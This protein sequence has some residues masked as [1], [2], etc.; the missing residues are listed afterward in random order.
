MKMVNRILKRFGLKRLSL[1]LDQRFILMGILS[2]TAK[3]LFRKALALEL[4]KKLDFTTREIKKAGIEISNQEG[5][6]LIQLAVK[7]HEITRTF[8]ITEAQRKGILEALKSLP[9]EILDNWIYV[10]I[11][12][13]VADSQG[14]L[15]ELFDLT[16]E[17]EKKE[18]DVDSNQNMDNLER[19]GRR[20]P[21]PEP[22]T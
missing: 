21:D 16:R 11:G 10:E 6:G 3:D 15:R 7:K 9:K 8:W 5:T 14:E 2:T 4:K 22:T 17:K 12:F 18:K 1:R 19:P 13:Q 20:Q